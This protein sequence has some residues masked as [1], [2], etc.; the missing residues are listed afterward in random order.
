MTSTKI[1]VG[2]LVP[3]VEARQLVCSQVS[4]TGLASVAVESDQYCAVAGDQAARR[5]IEV[6]PDVIL[7][8][9]QDLQAGIQSLTTL[10]AALPETRLFAMS[11]N[12]D[13]QLIIETMH[14]GAREFL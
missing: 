11:E 10:H 9:I 4:S 1:R 8:D 7:I 14:A 13:T 6:R 2:I 5:F 12:S 3:S